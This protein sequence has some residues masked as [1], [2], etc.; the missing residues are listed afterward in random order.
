MSEVYMTAGQ[1]FV[2]MQ[3]SFRRVLCPILFTF[4]FSL[5]VAYPLTSFFADF[6]GVT[7]HT[8]SPYETFET[9][10]LL[11]VF[12]GILFSIPLLTYALYDFF[13]SFSNIRLSVYIGFG[14]LLSL[15]GVGFG[16]T[17][18]A[19]FLL[20]ML[21]QYSIGSVT[22]GLYSVLKFMIYMGVATALVMQILILIPTLNRFKLVNVS[23]FKKR[24]KYVILS[25]FVLSA[26][27]TPPDVLSQ[28]VISIPFYIC[29]EGGILLTKIL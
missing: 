1:H 18:L 11:A 6:S 2:E 10:I 19:Y 25:I 28:V 12:L 21:Q 9:V 22:W 29:F 15:L 24:R 26:F 13:G 23:F 17:Y 7:V 3:N 16:S 27:L 8:L 20:M 4:F 5:F 14:Y